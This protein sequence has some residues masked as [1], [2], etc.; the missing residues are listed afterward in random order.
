[1]SEKK[2]KGNNEEELKESA[3]EYAESAGVKLNPDD[4]IVSG[5]LKG[6]LKNK[7]MKDALYCPCRLPTGDKEKDKEI[8]C[9]CVF[10]RDEI[11][12]EG[13]CKCFLFATRV[14]GAAQRKSVSG[15][16]WGLLFQI[17]PLFCRKISRNG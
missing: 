12:L 7:E 14:H 2:L 3:E 5:I 8:E 1:M 15:R 6:L 13:H 17:W 4:K 9:P 11:E 10:Y 16:Y